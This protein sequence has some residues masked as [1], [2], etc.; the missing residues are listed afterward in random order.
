MKNKYLYLPR[1]RLYSDDQRDREIQEWL[2]KLPKGAKSETIKE[3]I[4]AS[5]KQQPGRTFGPSQPL[6]P[7]TARINS[8]ST[9]RAE[10]TFDT[11]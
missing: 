9:M 2:S 7:E 8:T 11:H 1:V 3:A 4:W 6:K 5:I 10:G